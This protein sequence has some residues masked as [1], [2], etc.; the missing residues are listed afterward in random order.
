[1]QTIY[2]I[3]LPSRYCMT[4]AKETRDSIPPAPQSRRPC[5]RTFL[6]CFIPNPGAP[7]ANL[8]T[9]RHPGPAFAGQAAAGG[10]AFDSLT[11]ICRALLGKF[12]LFSSWPPARP[13][14]RIWRF[15]RRIGAQTVT[16]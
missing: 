9:T 1:M 10:I 14:R 2:T 5:G 12:R 4:A 15:A 8:P 11:G 7:R 3:E 16:E 13:W 6:H